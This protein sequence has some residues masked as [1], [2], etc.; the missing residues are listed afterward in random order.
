M[1]RIAFA[2]AFLILLIPYATTAQQ[3]RY[4]ANWKSLDS[5]PIPQWYDDSK[6]G[7]F[8]HWSLNSVPE[9]PVKSMEADWLWNSLKD[10]NSASS[11][12]WRAMYG[13]KF[14]YQDLAPLFKAE[15]FAPDKWADLFAR[16]GAK[17]VVLTSKHHDG[18]C[19]F[20]S[21]YSWNWN[22]VDVGPHRD[23]VGDLS[24]AVRA[25]GLKMGL[26]YSLYEWFHPWYLSDQ[27][28]FVD[29]HMFPQIKEVVT[30]YKPSVLWTDGEWDRTSAQWKSEKILE[31]LYNESPVRDDVVVNDRWGSE[32]R[33][34]HGGFYTS[35]FGGK[36]GWT[37]L[38]GMK[39]WE[40]CRCVARS[41]WGFARND[42]PSD[43]RTT[44]ELVH[45]LVEIVSRGGNLLLNV[46]PTRDGR[47]PVI[48]QERLLELG[49]WL[50]VNGEAIYGT[51]TWR[52]MSDGKNI[53]DTT[54]D[55][56]DW[57][58][59]YS[60]TK[61]IRYTAKENAVYAIS[62]VWPGKELALGEPKPSPDAT[63]TMLGRSGTLKWRIVDGKMRIEV[64]Q[65]S[66]DELPSRH[67]YVFK[68]IGVK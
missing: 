7:I 13:D 1:K 37:K 56:D 22:S 17:Y 3:K 46:G 44:T 5:R 32:T 34:A 54:A 38:S 35:E 59:K 18:F 12:T 49:D 40:E 29:S 65:L 53:K 64:P 47:I 45:M 41:W 27:A 2:I 55:P 4:E 63:V 61:S 57:Q 24:K 8:V 19:L 20:Q 14:Q 25:K 67:A 43:Y 42:S 51:H 23:I 30:R 16:S 50:R 66:L 52:A 11:K 26:Y 39:K 21:D 48:T 31:W 36:D 60:T 15:L 9:L 6:F 28:L 58:N 33:G 68:I 10:P 62:L